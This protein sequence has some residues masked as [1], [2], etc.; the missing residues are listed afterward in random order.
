MF[1]SCARSLAADIPRRLTRSL[2]AGIYVPHHLKQLSDALFTPMT[3]GR[4]MIVGQPRYK[5]P[6]A[7]VPPPKEVAELLSA[8]RSCESRPFRIV[9]YE[10]DSGKVFNCSFFNDADHMHS[11]CVPSIFTEPLQSE[12]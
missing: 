4:C 6:I 3:T 7:V 5:Y 1:P 9:S 10:E 11:W 8:I 2:S 12:L